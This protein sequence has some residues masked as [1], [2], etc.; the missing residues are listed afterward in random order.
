MRREEGEGKR[1]RERKGS[2]KRAERIGCGGEFGVGSTR[3]K[4]WMSTKMAGTPELDD[5]AQ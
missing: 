3:G 2:L 4:A 5:A 1:R